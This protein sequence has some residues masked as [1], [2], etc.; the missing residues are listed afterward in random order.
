MKVLLA[1]PPMTQINTPYPATAYLTGFLK[2]EN[3][4]VSQRDVGLELFLKLFSKPGLNRILHELEK[5]KIKGEEPVSPSVRWFLKSSQDYI[6]SVETVVRFLQGKDS[7]LSYL[8]SRRGFLPEGPRFKV[9]KDWENTGDGELHWAFGSLGNQDRA[10]YLASLFIDDLTDMIR[11]G[12]DSRFELSRYAEKLAAS[13]PSFDP[14]L[15]ALSKTPTLVDTVLDEIWSEI[16][17]IEKPEVIGFSL[18]FPGNVYAAFRMAKLSKTFLPKTP[19]I[20]G[21]GYVNTELRELKDA[22]VFDFFDYITLDDGERPFLTLLQNLKNPDSSPKFLRTFLRENAEVVQKNDSLHD[23]PLKDSGIPTYEGLLLDRYLSLNEGLNP[24]HRLWSDG[25]WNKLTLAHGCYWKKC[26]FCDT[27]LDYINRYEPQ[28][29]K[30][31]VDRIEKL[32]QETGETGFHF[33]DEAAPPKILVAM[34]EELIRRGIKI[35]WWGNIRFEKAFTPAVTK[36]LARSGCVAVSGGLEVASDRLLKLMEKGVTVEQV[37]SV[38]GAFSEAGILVHAYLMFGFPTQTLQ[39]TVDSLERVRQLFEAGCIQSAFWH[40]FSVTAHSPIGKNPEKYGIQLKRV[41]STFAKNDIEFFDPT[42][43]DHEALYP[44]LKKAVYNYMLGLGLEE[45][46]RAWFD[47]SVPKAKVS[48][49]LIQKSL[50]RIRDQGAVMELLVAFFI[51]L[52]AGSSL[53]HADIVALPDAIN[54]KEGIG[55]LN[56]ELFDKTV[57]NPELRKAGLMEC[58]EIKDLKG[59]ILCASSK[60]NLMNKAFSRPTVFA[61]G[62]SQLEKGKIVS[63]DSEAYLKSLTEISGHDLL[64]NQLLSFWTELQQVCQWQDICPTPEEEE[65]FKEVVLPMSQKQEPF[66]VIAYSVNGDW[67]YVLSHELP[68]AQYFLDIKYRQAVDSFWSETVTEEDRAK[69]KKVLGEAYN[70]NDDVLMRNE[71]QAFLLESR[72]AEDRLKDF[73]PLYRDKL[74]KQLEEAGSAPLKF[75]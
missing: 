49:S 5:K 21:G 61:E 32:I 42:G 34:A 40:R 13:A 53:L 43:C 17:E 4:E 68:H 59:L 33:V 47:F 3:F 69:V 75:Q 22:R 55:K 51:W 20:V 23:I 65:M 15:S 54:L 26:T 52:A 25:R 14:I 10:K 29:A 2:Q 9:L 56:Y 18:P 48:S 24:M 12:V 71:F 11:D 31:I 74:I 67:S 62:D 35:T 58:V 64:S 63:T 6:D 27:S 66:V 37:A 73:V 1:T 8:I 38:T 19:V 39:E 41:E 70:P 16:L 46:V 30:L 7:T 28:G 44:G 50:A 45:D 60:K 72:A 36:L 57:S